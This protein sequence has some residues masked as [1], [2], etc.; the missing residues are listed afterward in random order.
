MEQLKGITVKELLLKFMECHK[1]SK[2]SIETLLN[3]QRI[4]DGSLENYIVMDNAGGKRFEIIER[5][6]EHLTQIL[7]KEN[8]VFF[9]YT[10]LACLNGV[11]YVNRRSNVFW[12][13]K[14]H[15]PDYVA[16][17]PKNEYITLYPRD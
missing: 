3:F 16:P 9:Q 1:E 14:E 2:I 17:T 15:M 8:D 4:C 11:E 12:F 7:A 10:F 5:S 6:T 13:I